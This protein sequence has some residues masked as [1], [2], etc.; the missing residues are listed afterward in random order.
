[1]NEV[2]STSGGSVPEIDPSA[3]EAAV[4]EAASNAVQGATI[5]LL[6]D[7]PG[8]ADLGAPAGAQRSVVL[9]DAAAMTGIP[10]QE[11]PSNGQTTVRF[12]YKTSPATLAPATS[13]ALGAAQ[14]LDSPQPMDSLGGCVRPGSGLVSWRQAEGNANDSAGS[15]PGQTPNGADFVAGEVGQAFSLNAVN[16]MN[17]SIQL[18][19]P[20]GMA[21]PSFSVEAWVNPAHQIGSQAF[22]FGQAY[23]RQ[24]VVR[25]GA[26]GATVAFFVTDMNGSFYGVTSTNVIPIGQWT[27]LAGTWDGTKLKL[28]LNGAQDRNASLQLSAIGNSGCPFSIGGINNSCGYSGQ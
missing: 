3:A 16:G 8:P 9:T 19:N 23:G 25:P 13:R 28:F 24:L 12:V 5:L 6:P 21:T 7:Q 20:S 17:Q 1:M 11:A 2:T 10:I 27:H 15:N 26:V 4:L 18:P 22:V 14:T